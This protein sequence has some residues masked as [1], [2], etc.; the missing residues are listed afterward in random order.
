MIRNSNSILANDFL[1]DLVSICDDIFYRSLAAGW[2]HVV[3]ACV[4]HVVLA[5][6]MH[7]ERACLIN[8]TT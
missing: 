8:V 5:Y 7:M 6:V 1:A 3:L 2:M 4:M